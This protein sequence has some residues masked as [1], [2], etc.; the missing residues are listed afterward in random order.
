LSDC[1]SILTHQ[2]NLKYK[3]SLKLIYVRAAVRRAIAQHFT[4][5]GVD[6]RL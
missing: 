1:G 6:C 4:G 5:Y 3:A 2:Q